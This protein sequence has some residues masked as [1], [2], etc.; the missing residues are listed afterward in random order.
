MKNSIFNWS[1][2]KDSAFCLYHC[3]KD[4][5]INIKYLLTTLNKDYNRISMHGVR[6]ELLLAQA[7]RIG[8]PLKE[9]LLPEAASLS[10][11]NKL[12]KQT[13]TKFKSEEID[14]SIFGDIFLE[15]LKD[16]RK[17]KL[18]LQQIFLYHSRENN[19]TEKIS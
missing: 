9:V 14:Y 6:R 18:S 4:N 10:V 8:I 16:Y 2:G 12:M 17:E 11:Y 15:D 7:E 3:L 13:L 5:S 19:L 1:G